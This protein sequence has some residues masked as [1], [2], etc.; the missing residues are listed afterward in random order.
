MSLAL[1]PQTITKLE[2][3]KA[4]RPHGIL[5]SAPKGSGKG[6]IA[7]LLAEW[8]IG[9]ENGLDTYAYF[10]SIDSADGKGIGIEAIR[11][12]EHFLSLKV[13]GKNPTNRLVLI[14]D[15]H[16][17]THEAQNAL[18]KTLEE[19]PAATNIILTASHEQS[20]LPTIRSRVQTVHL[21]RPEKTELLKI[22][23]SQGFNEDLISQAYSIS[24]GLPGLMHALLSDEEHSL[25]EA[26]RRTRVLLSQ[27]TYERLLNVDELSKNREL[28]AGIT[29]IMQQMAHVS[30]QTARGAAAIKWRAILDSSYAASEALVKNGSP[31]LVLTKLMLTL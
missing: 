21:I 30:L 2:A 18:L 25:L 16:L 15:A 19:P 14:E 9:L 5:L 12:L 1:H 7:R 27:T 23:K 24:G 22:F 10:R 31:K 4:G 26:T 11:D 3:V 13:P 8:L 20:L 6:A 17:L 29:L 28:A